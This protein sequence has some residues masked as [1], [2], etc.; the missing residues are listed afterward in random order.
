MLFNN[1][2]AAS[3]PTC[4]Y[5]VPPRTRSSTFESGSLSASSIWIRSCRVR[6]FIL[7]SKN[8]KIGSIFEHFGNRM[9]I[10]LWQLSRF[11]KVSPVLSKGTVSPHPFIHLVIL[12]H[13]C[14][15]QATW[16]CKWPL[17]SLVLNQK[18]PPYWK[19]QGVIHAL[20]D[21]WTQQRTLS[22]T[23]THTSYLKSKHKKHINKNNM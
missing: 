20:R 5:F 4:A 6:R 11:I 2:R 1:E 18:Y 8:W 12:V 19:Y 10:L 23:G 22:V 16:V 21:P 9:S 17:V 14:G 13:H 15:E 3:F 7:W